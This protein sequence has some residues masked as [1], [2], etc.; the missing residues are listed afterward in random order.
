MIS[1]ALRAT[2]NSS[3]VRLRACV[4]PTVEKVAS[5][6]TAPKAL[7]MFDCL[8]GAFLTSEERAQQQDQDRDANSG[9]AHIEY[10]KRPERAEVQ[11][12]KDDDIAVAHP[13]EDVAERT[14]QHH[15]E[16]DLVDAVL[17]APDPHCD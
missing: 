13:V 14:A 2:A 12:G 17:L 5:R 4:Q 7:R 3:G 10:Q 6:R 11:V 8:L 1:G 9:I 15:A 16:R